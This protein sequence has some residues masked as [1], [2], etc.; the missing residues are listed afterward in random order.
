MLRACG[1]VVLIWSGWWALAAF[2]LS[3]G[4]DTWMADRRAM[5]WQAEAT[6]VHVSGYPLSLVA[7][8][9]GPALADPQT[10]VAVQA[11]TLELRAPAWW[12][13]Y[14][15]LRFPEDPILL[16][17]PL[18]R[19]FLK[20]SQAQADL[21]LH[22][23]VS[24]QL[25]KMALTSGRWELDGGQGQLANARGITVLAEQSRIAPD[26]YQFNID[27]PH[28]IPGAS[29][30]HELFIPKDWPV[31]FDRV[32]MDMTVG[33]T[34]PW[35]RRAVEVARPQPRRID[36]RLAEASWGDL[37]VRV[38]AKLDIAADGVPSGKL[39]V[40]ARNWRDI[41]DLAVNSGS[42]PLQ[43]RPQVEGVLTAL[44]GAS[45]DPDAFDV[46]LT[47]AAG[48]IRM[49]FLPLGPAPRVILR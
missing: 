27:I 41:L 35:D 12:P 7:E 29:L 8:I 40:Q 1:I 36:L 13:G 10:G 47:L 21:R 30:R 33:F 9:R 11:S 24:M 45:G 16:A 25:D 19:M 20:T 15:T 3:S 6:D 5:G 14:A 37:L 49:G 17:T 28:L 18:R 2:G 38:A 43:I 31:A 44:A 23:G 4:I 46:T 48:Q 32:K 22:P 39:S 26:T 42:L 34:R